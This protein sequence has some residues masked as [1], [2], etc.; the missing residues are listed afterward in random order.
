SLTKGCRSTGEDRREEASKTYFS[1]HWY[2]RS[3]SSF[4]FGL[5][6]GTRMIA[7]TL[8][9][10]PVAMNSAIRAPELNPLEMFRFQ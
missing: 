6:I 3:S 7:D 8:G 4:L 2:T 1:Y 5:D 9:H 10:V